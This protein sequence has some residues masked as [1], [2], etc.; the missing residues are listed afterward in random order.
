[1]GGDDGNGMMGRGRRRG[2]EEKKIGREFG[3]GGRGRA[4]AKASKG[5]KQVK[6]AETAGCVRDLESYVEV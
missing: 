5:K 4:D 3:R 1:M 2:S 6:R